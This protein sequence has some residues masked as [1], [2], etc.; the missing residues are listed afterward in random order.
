MEL[1]NFKLFLVETAQTCSLFW[2]CRVWVNPCPVAPPCG[3][4]TNM[5]DSSYKQL[6]MKYSK[7][8][9]W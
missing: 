7:R 1:R 9:L 3:G 6:T 4:F 8:L 2:D 5:H